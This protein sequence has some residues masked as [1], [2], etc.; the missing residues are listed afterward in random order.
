MAHFYDMVLCWCLVSKDFALL[1]DVHE[2]ESHLTR[3]HIKLGLRN[4]CMCV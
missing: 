2:N 1:L 3:R 4:R